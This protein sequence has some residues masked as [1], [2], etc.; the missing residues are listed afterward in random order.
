M[1]QHKEEPANQIHQMHHQAAPQQPPSQ[2]EFSTTP[3][4]H[5][6]PQ[7]L[8]LLLLLT[9]LKGGNLGT[10][11]I[12][13][14]L[15]VKRKNYFL[16]SIITWLATSTRALAFSFLEK[17]DLLPAVTAERLHIAR[18]LNANKMTCR[19]LQ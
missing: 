19:S 10:C 15:F 5:I 12:H 13:V 8:L 14:C 17:L 7:Q 11:M 1:P 4:Q 6:K 9:F 18:T 3:W 2:E 16:K